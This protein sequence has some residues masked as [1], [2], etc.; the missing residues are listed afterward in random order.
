MQGPDTSLAAPTSA[1]AALAM[2]EAAFDFLNSADLAGL[3][4][5]MLAEGL[6][7]WTRLDAK[8]A[9][10]E[11]K[12][13]GAFDAQQGYVA[14]AQRSTGAWLRLF[15]GQTDA[16]ARGQVASA[17]RHAAHRAV[18]DA[19]SRGDFSESYG[20]WICT[21]VRK[22]PR[23]DQGAVEEILVEAAA[24]GLQIEDL[25][26]LAAEIMQRIHPNGMPE[27]E[28]RIDAERGVTLGKTLGGVGR[29]NGDLTKHATALTDTVLE[30]LAVKRGPEDLRTAKQRRHDALV[31]AFQLLV[32]SDLMP[33]RGGAK[34]QV[35]VDLPFDTL[36]RLPHAAQLEEEWI[37][38][39]LTALARA[40]LDDVCP[41]DPRAWDTDEPT[42]PAQASEEFPG[43][44]GRLSP[45]CSPD[46]TAGEVAG[47]CGTG[48]KGVFGGSPAVLGGIGAISDRLAAALHCDS[49][50]TPVVTG[51]VNRDALAQMTGHWLHAHGM[52]PAELTE[53]SWLRLQETLLRWAIDVLSGE[54]GLAAY[55]RT[56][57][58]QGPLT[59]PSIV[60]DAGR[61]SRTIPAALERAVRRRDRR[62][63]FPGCDVPAELAQVHH[64]TEWDHG[65]TH[66]LDNLLILC[67]FHHLIAVHAW[68]WMITAHPDGT[69]TATSPQGRTLYEPPG[70]CNDPPRAA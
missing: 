35:K 48:L 9:A 19:E 33:A 69:I 58:L 24:Q 66:R 32:D 7:Q 54:T 52:T 1:G 59:T 27:D 23:D 16:A 60:L 8:R 41:Q 30:A 12:L 53:S 38:G 13:T 39:K 70:R 65:G 14:Q 29:L 6:K 46:D 26:M 49:T 37:Q 25:A 61:D 47:V 21:A 51:N 4:G 62:C 3:P 50:L 10:A 57:L 20:R 42:R 56:G 43:A 34:A 2:A 36:R 17:K 31:Q 67:S 28:D 18:A 22:F 15:A 40:R 45:D 64:L 63:R 68:G 44:S 55:L 5:E 11:A